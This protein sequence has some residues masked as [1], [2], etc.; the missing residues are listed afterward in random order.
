MTNKTPFFLLIF[1]ISISSFAQNDTIVDYI[2]KAK[3]KFVEKDEAYFIRKITEKNKNYQ[4]LYYLM[5]GNL[6]SDETF[7]DEKLNYQVGNHTFYHDNGKLQLTKKYNDQSQLNGEFQTFYED[8]SANFGGV[9]KNGKKDGVWNYHYTNGNKI[10]MLVYEEGEVKDYSLWN[11]DGTEKKEKL[12][13]ERRPKY[14]GGQKAMAN[15]IRKNLAPRFKKSEF[16]GRLILSFTVNKEGRP[17]AIKIH[18]KNLSEDDVKSIHAF[19]A[20]M[21]NWEPGIQLNRKV[22]VKYTLPVRIN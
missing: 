22:K 14:K 15:F 7:S 10:A 17:E 5:N 2:D 21:P 8:G 13:L 4:V 18:P 19:F 1:L 9:Y 6:V 20:E 12:I 3:S 16:K 11:R